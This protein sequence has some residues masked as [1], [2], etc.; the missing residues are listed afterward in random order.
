MSSEP[1]YVF[2]M[3][4][5]QPEGMRLDGRTFFVWRGLDAAGDDGD[6]E[7]R[8]ATRGGKLVVFDSEE[9]CWSFALEAGWPTITPEDRDSDA[10]VMDLD[11]ALDW[12]R[13]RRATVD[14][15]S[16][17]DLWNMTTEVAF[18]TGRRFDDRGRVR[19][20]CY[21]KLF[22]ANVPYAFDLVAYVPRWK[23]QELRVL[24]EVLGQAVHVFREPLPA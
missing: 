10:Q 21:T 4:N 24:R 15:A 3:D 20:N 14:P 7:D 11:P 5:A 19:E 16:A 17:L 6:Q 18:S 12:L 9:E 23:P 2:P 22:A 1:R 8:L 13:G